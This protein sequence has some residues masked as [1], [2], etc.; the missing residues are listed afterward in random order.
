MN[1]RTKAAAKV[2]AGTA[3][4]EHFEL[5]GPEAVA[6]IKSNRSI[7]QVRAKASDRITHNKDTRT[8][9]YIASDETPDRVGDIISV[10]GWQTDLYK[11]NPVILWG[12]DQSIPPIGRGRNVR[13]R[14]NGNP[15]LT[16]DIQFAP[17]E[18][19]EFA[20]TIYQLASRDYLRATSVGF[21]PKE[22]KNVSDKQRTKLGLGKYGQFYSAAELMEISVVSVPANPSALEDGIKAMAQAGVFDKKLGTRFLEK[23]VMTSDVAIAR[24]KEACRSFVDMGALRQEINQTLNE[25]DPVEKAIP[26]ALDADLET[27]SP[28]CRQ[29]GE[30]KQ[31]CV[32]RKIPELVDEGMEQDQAVAVANSVCETSCDEKQTTSSVTKDLDNLRQSRDL[33][34]DGVD[35]LD[36]AISQY[37]G[38]Q[39]PSDEDSYEDEER[40]QKRRVRK[41]TEGVR[42]HEAKMLNA[43]AW[44]IEQ[45]A[46]QARATRSL[47]DALADLTNKLHNDLPSGNGREAKSSDAALPDAG[48]EKEDVARKSDSAIRGFAD[49]WKRAYLSNDNPNTGMNSN[50]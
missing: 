39:E 14:Y 33:I 35:F 23:Y 42:T 18:A 47:V 11:R 49:N 13:R 8:I 44:L 45:Q 43:V 32:E 36:M 15:R 50:V 3:T 31:D 17:V 28:A 20:D 22:T 24:V 38:E 5:L 34:L 21:I 26:E 29:E 6:E 7:L 19:H 48:I 27:K 12:H 2:A 40:S 41:D 10:R 46:E 30:T 37:E 16:V 9:T 4:D 25:D 1:E